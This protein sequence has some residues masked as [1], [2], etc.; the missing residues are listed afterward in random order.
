LLCCACEE[1]LK[2]ANKD[3][4]KVV[5]EEDKGGIIVAGVALAANKPF[6]MIRWYPSGIPGQAQSSTG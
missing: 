6:G 1:I 2:V 4:E 5:G 3:F